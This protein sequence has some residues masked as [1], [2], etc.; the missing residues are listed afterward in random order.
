VCLGARAHN[1]SNVM[2]APL[3]YMLVL[4]V[5]VVTV[6]SKVKECPSAELPASA[7]KFTSWWSNESGRRAVTVKR[8]L[9]S[10]LA[11]P[12]RPR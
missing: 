4:S 8:A 10:T 6:L 12:L 7:R 2:A 5:L 11:S 1:L 3:G 9:G